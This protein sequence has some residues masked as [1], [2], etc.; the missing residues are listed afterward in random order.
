MVKK[1]LR[2]FGAG[3]RSWR[4]SRRTLAANPRQ[5]FADDSFTPPAARPHLNDTTH[6]TLLAFRAGASVE[7]IARR[8]GLVAGTIHTHLLTAIEAGRTDRV[9]PA[10]ELRSSSGKLPRPLE[11][12]GYGNLT[13]ARELLG[14]TIDYGLLRIY[15][16]AR[17]AK[18]KKFEQQTPRRWGWGIPAQLKKR[19]VARTGCN[20]A[21]NADN[22]NVFAM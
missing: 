19:S 14:E 11:R 17:H 10:V 8:R 13:G 21:G 6:A 3:G 18:C 22:V 15:R 12:T 5:I 2:E 20:T 1:K 9:G 16:A 7:E 4:R